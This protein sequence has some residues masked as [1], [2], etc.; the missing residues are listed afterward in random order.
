MTDISPPRTLGQ[1]LLGRVLTTAVV[2]DLDLITPRMRRVRLAGDAVTGLPWTPGQHVRVLI[3]D[4][5]APRN[6]AHPKD[7]LRTYSVWALGT[8]LDL[9]VLDHGD[10]PGARWARALEPGQEVTFTKPEGSLVAGEGAYHLFAGEE[11]A[12]VAFGPMLA[13][14]PARAP[15]YGVLE[16][17]GPDDHLRLARELTWI[18]R[19]SGS[20]A[21]SES[22]LDAVRALDLPEEPGIAYLAG[23]AK[24]IQLLRSHL[25]GE[26][27]WPRRNVVTKP[28][29]TPGKVGMD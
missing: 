29:W 15:V 23:E 28:F 5:L 9:C 18:H 21:S 8:T 24:T 27:G 2:V 14:L 13:D 10:G 19:S 3:T 26:R 22:L 12:A 6:W 20:A 11:T 4:P 17:E 25:V 16:V 1:R 7:F